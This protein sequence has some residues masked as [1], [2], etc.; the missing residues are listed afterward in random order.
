MLPALTRRRVAALQISNRISHEDTKENQD[1]DQSGDWRSQ[2]NYMA[3][4]SGKDAQPT[5][6][7]RNK[8]GFTQRSGGAE[9]NTVKNTLED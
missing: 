9:R 4:V 7:R 1:D 8:T 2:E 5:F 6:H 3:A